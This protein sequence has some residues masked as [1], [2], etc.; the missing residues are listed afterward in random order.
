MEVSK[1][2]RGEMV[3]AIGGLLLVFSVFLPAYSPSSTNRNASVAG[4]R[5]DASIWEANALSRVVLLV[6][7]L[8]PIVLLYVI[9][10]G[11]ELSWPRG[12]LTA[13]LGLVA[14]TLVVWNGIIQRPGEPAGQVGLTIGW[15]LAL[16]GSLA[17]AGGGAVRASMSE[18]RRKPPGVL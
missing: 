4:G 2:R 18:R 9:V 3:A 13:V 1:L 6:A 15:F 17:V 11:H 16:L 5:A 14:V 7:A 10:R 12:E 8:A